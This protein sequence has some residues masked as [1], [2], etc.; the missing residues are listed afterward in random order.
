MKK[1]FFPIIVFISVFI[2]G[3]N[4]DFEVINTNPNNP[5]VIYPELLMVN[6]IRG[7]V[8]DL[9]GD[10]FSSSNVLMQFMTQ[11]REPG[12]D[13]YQIGSTN[14]WDNGYSNLRNV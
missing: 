10:G 3:C 14:T 2:S 12:I 8:N 13:R 1:I 5:E 11:V 9:V 7:S 6:I 4:K